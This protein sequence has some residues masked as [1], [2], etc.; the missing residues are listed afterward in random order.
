MINSVFEGCHPIFPPLGNEAGIDGIEM[1]RARLPDGSERI[2]P[3]ISVRTIHNDEINERHEGGED[4]FDVIEEYTTW[5]WVNDRASFAAAFRAARMISKGGKIFAADLPPR[6]LF[7][8]HDID[9]KPVEAVVD[10]SVHHLPEA[11]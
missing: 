8:L 2:L 1:W 6:T 4:A 11:V 7:Y 9:G 10:C 3:M 5:F